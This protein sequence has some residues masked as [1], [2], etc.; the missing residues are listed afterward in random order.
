MQI[1][2]WAF[3]NETLQIFDMFG[4]DTEAKRKW[5]TG[6]EELLSLRI[7]QPTPLGMLAWLR[8]AIAPRVKARFSTKSS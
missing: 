3:A 2:R 6:A 8:Y 5:A 1:P 4:P 7:F